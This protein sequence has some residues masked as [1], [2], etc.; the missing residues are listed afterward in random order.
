MV[1]LLVQLPTVSV[2]LWFTLVCGL[3]IL[4]I[5]RPR[6]ARALTA[7]CVVGLIVFVGGVV[8]GQIQCPQCFDG[9]CPDL[10]AYGICWPIGWWPC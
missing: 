10:V 6:L 8:S 5:Y 4:A 7:V 9:C 3:A 2:P 1:S